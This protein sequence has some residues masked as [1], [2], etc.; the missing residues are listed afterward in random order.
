MHKNGNSAE[1]RSSALFSQAK[2][3]QTLGCESMCQHHAHAPGGEL[4]LVLPSSK[5]REMFAVYFHHRHHHQIIGIVDVAATESEPLSWLALMVLPLFTTTIANILVI[6]IIIAL[7]IVTDTVLL[8]IAINPL[9]IAITIIATIL[10][11]DII[12]VMTIVISLLL[13]LL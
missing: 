7:V 12:I 9:I 1:G 6:A 3:R 10:L 4:L 2:L 13:L 5:N 8:V 11:T